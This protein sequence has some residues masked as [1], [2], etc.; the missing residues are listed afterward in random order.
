MRFSI[1]LS[2]PK[3][4][5]INRFTSGRRA[6]LLVTADFP[7]S[8]IIDVYVHLLAL[9]LTNLPRIFSSWHEHTHTTIREVLHS[10]TKRVRHPA[11]PNP[12]PAFIC[13]GP[14][15]TRPSSHFTVSLV[16]LLICRPVTSESSR[17]L[18]LA[19]SPALPSLA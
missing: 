13:R 1:V 17:Q 15:S 11:S 7:I 4:R 8:E 9:P 3:Q 2:R 16:D 5:L 6:S 18:N 10:C 12:L 19:K 14:T